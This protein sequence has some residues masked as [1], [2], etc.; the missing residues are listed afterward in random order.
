MLGYG[1]TKALRWK[2]E[3]CGK[4]LH[5]LYLKQLDFL[6]AQHKLKHKGEPRQVKNPVKASAK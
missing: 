2:C 1:M 3:R 4:I 6:V 5:S